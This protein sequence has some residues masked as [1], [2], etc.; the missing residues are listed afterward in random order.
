MAAALEFLETTKRY[1]ERL[2]LDSLT[3]AVTP[4]EIFGFLGPNGAGKTTA[5]HC[6]M[7]FLQATGGSGRMLG[8]PFGVTAVRARVGFVP[9][10][11]VFFA[12][13]AE[14][15]LDL[16][17][18]LNGLP[19]SER[20]QR[21]RYLLELLDLPSGGRDAR[22]FSR[23]M[24]QRL[25]LAQALVNRP[26]LLIL[27]EPTSALDPPGVLAVRR[28][29]AAARDEGTA[30]F[31]S[32]HQLTEVEQLCDRVGFLS[33]GRL[34]RSGSIREMLEEGSTVEVV[35]RGLRSVPPPW[36][37]VQRGG[38]LVF[39]VPAGRER[40]LIEQAWAAG[41]ELVSV[42]R[43]KRSLEEI[44]LTNSGGAA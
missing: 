26:E 11:P 24:Q 31:F 40:E 12:G 7:G 8:K 43:R 2:A 36:A 23:G 44:F 30:I 38:E 15:S 32:S 18:R 4:G 22:R 3:L 29:L 9:D 20:K 25:G 39:E 34:V 10:A 16:A 1:G 17:G 35:V 27:D 28:L 42:V 21:A 41:G 37:G 5:L 33:N 14:Q 6:A 19:T 13:T